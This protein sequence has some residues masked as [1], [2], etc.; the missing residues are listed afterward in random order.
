MLK[1]IFLL[2]LIS[3]SLFPEEKIDNTEFIKKI[4]GLK[5]QTGK[6]TIGNKLATV[7]IPNKFKFLDKEQARFVLESVWGNPKNDSILGMFL[8]K[9]EAPISNDFSYAVTFSY[10]EEGYIKDD[11]AKE[12]N[13]DDLL[14]EMK[15]DFVEANKE[16][17]KEGFPTL[18][19]I[20]WASSPFYDD[21]E[22]KL[23]WA[24][25]IKFEGNEVNTLNYNIRI[26]GRKGVL[27]LNIISDIQKLDLVK[28]DIQLILASTEFNDGKRY[29]DFNPSLDEVAAYGIGGLIAGKVL[30]KA[31]LLAV[32]LKFWKVIALGFVGA[33]A[34]LKRIFNKEKN[35][36]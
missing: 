25:E 36:S 32:L 14:K 1:K 10:S 21:K 13:Y 29:S 23:H 11:D 30:A 27:V 18:E 4:T 12:I 24:K 33:F 3:F 6:V 31:G 22:K 5:Y 20:G 7:S 35:E 9:D 2:I 28:K 16:R 8:L 19:L 17:K 26:L 34:F 15:S